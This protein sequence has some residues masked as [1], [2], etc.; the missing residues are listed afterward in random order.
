MSAKRYGKEII[1]IVV[2]AVKHSEG[3]LSLRFEEDDCFIECEGKRIGQ[4]IDHH[5][6]G[7]NHTFDGLI[8]FCVEILHPIK[9]HGLSES[10]RQA[11][12]LLDCLFKR[13]HDAKY[14]EA[15]REFYLLMPRI[16]KSM[17]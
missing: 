11:A 10:Y 3:R 4:S 2:A 8:V 15:F 1:C 7:C 5:I 16:R 14:H 13:V 12:E 17:T 9:K 6:H